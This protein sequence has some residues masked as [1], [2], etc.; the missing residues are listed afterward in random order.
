MDM[1]VYRFERMPQKTRWGECEEVVILAEH[2]D[3]AWGIL[4]SG[5]LMHQISDFRLVSKSVAEVGEIFSTSYTLG[6]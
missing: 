6:V 4:T 5:R 1:I 3:Q 2:E